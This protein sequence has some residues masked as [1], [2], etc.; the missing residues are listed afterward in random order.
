M[1]MPIPIPTPKGELAYDAE[2]VFVF[3]LFALVEGPNLSF[4][5]MDFLGVFDMILFFY[6]F[7]YVFG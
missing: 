1:A 4:S 5:S 7:F 3:V 6:S 2:F